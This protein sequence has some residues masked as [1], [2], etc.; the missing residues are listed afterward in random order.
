MLSTLNPEHELYPPIKHYYIP[1]PRCS[2]ITENR[3]DLFKN[4]LS[5]SSNTPM[6]WKH[7]GEGMGQNF[8]GWCPTLHNKEVPGLSHPVANDLGWTAI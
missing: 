3:S 7:Y 1:F 2:V 8:K 5:E 4:F 6:N